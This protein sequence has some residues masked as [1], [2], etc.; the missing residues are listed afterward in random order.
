MPKITTEKIIKFLL[1]GENGKS[2]I[3]DYG[4]DGDYIYVEVDDI[5]WGRIDLNKLMRFM[6]NT[7][8]ECYLVEDENKVVFVNL[9]KTCNVIGKNELLRV[10]S[11][12]NILMSFIFGNKSISWNFKK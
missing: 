9:D 1:E 4:I 2:R 7:I 12:E 6:A 5:K 3:T 8:D 11:F 10:K